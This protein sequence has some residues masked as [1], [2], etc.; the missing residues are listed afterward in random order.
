M[1]IL[2]N[3]VK[4][5][6]VGVPGKTGQD[7][8]AATIK[9][10]TV[11]TGSPGTDVVI[12]NSGTENAAVLNFTIPRGSDGTQGPQGPAGDD[13]FYIVNL[14]KTGDN[15]TV[16]KTFAEMQAQMQANKPVVFA[17]NGSGTII[18]ATVLVGNIAGY[19][20]YPSVWSGT[21]IGELTMLT[22]GVTP[23]NVV[24]ATT[25]KLVGAGTDLVGTDYTANRV[26]GM[27]FQATTPA[28]IPNGCSVGVYE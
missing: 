11:S 27:A 20:V 5:A 10:G 16:D 2:I 12:T 19:W 17:L 6:G 18:P 25:R 28:S 21:E 23:E 7:G 9:I 14:T 13:K 15:F 26:R 4:V 1:A 3:G 8:K 22:V 24:Q